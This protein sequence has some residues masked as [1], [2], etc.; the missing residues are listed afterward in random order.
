MINII[1]ANATSPS[2]P[3][4]GFFYILKLTPEGWSCTAI[5]SEPGTTGERSFF[6]NQYG[7]IYYNIYSN[8]H[9]E[10]A[11]ENCNSLGNW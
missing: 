1:L 5:P 6:I 3:K 4:S 7:I 11:D 8:S 2:S 9:D 10:P